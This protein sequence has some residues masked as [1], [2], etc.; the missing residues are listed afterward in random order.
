MTYYEKIIN[1]D[2]YISNWLLEEND[3][4]NLEIEW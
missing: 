2:L 4:N 1:Q 3:L